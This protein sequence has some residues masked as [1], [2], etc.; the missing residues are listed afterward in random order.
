MENYT[1]SGVNSALK[2]FKILA[3]GANVIKLFQHNYIAIG[4]TSVEII[5]KYATSGINSA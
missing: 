4:V 2:S 5:G 3:T 1:T